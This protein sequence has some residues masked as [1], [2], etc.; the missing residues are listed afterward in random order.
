MENERII[1]IDEGVTSY[2]QMLSY[3]ADGYRVLCIQAA[4]SGLSPEKCD[5]LMDKYNKAFIKYRIALDEIVQEATEG[6]DLEGV[7][8]FV[9]FLRSVL[10]LRRA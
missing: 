4:D 6:E 1:P 5:E 2:L 10:V 8:Y 9:D 3:E 7:T